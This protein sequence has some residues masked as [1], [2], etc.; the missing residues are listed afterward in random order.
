MRQINRGSRQN[1][2]DAEEVRR[3][4]GKTPFQDVGLLRKPGRQAATGVSKRVIVLD[5]GACAEMPTP[6]RS[7]LNADREINRRDRDSQR[8]FGSLGESSSGL[9][10]YAPARGPG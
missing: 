10:A 9:H 5:D 7:H 1:R 2:E 3:R 6:A 8:R 4:S